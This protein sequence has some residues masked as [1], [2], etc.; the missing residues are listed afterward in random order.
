MSNKNHTKEQ[1]REFLKQEALKEISEI[2][3]FT[4]FQTRAF[5]VV[6]KYGLQLDAKKE[7]LFSGDEWSNLDCRDMLIEKMKQF[8]NKHIK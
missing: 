4:R 5:C 2:S 6:A 3:D 1:A 7:E 8:L